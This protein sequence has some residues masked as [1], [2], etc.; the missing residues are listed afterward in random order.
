MASQKS[1]SDTQALS[2][3]HDMLRYRA[4]AALPGHASTRRG[5]RGDQGGD[6]GEGNAPRAIGAQ[7]RRPATHLITSQAPTRAICAP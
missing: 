7:A 5:R 2:L 1:S 6:V 4:R 3:L